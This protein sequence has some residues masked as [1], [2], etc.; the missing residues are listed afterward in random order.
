MP[1]LRASID[2]PNYVVSDMGDVYSLH[3]GRY[4]PTR[5]VPKL[6]TPQTY[7]N[8]GRRYVQ[9]IDQSRRRVIRKVAT[10]VLEAFTGPCP[11]G[12]EIL[13]NNGNPADD[14]LENLRW[15]THKENME[16][17]EKHGRTARGERN[18]RYKLSPEQVRDI[19]TLT[20]TVAALKHGISP[21]YA[22]YIIKRKYRAEVT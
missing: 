22:A 14:R 4:G 15:G 11:P 5:T 19:R 2:P 16:D 20:P 17:R 12:L 21:Q 8:D 3:N 9:L 18:G 6:L 13:H 10:M 7:K 1:E